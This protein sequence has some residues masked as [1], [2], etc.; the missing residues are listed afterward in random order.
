PINLFISSADELFGPI[1]TIRHMGHPVVHILWSAFA[2]NVS[3][4]EH[5]NDVHGIV[6]DAN[7]LQQSFSS[8]NHGNTL[9]CSSCS[10]RTADKL[11]SEKKYNKV[12]A[13]P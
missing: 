11:G 13:I 2:L 10:Q 4:W 3:D 8:E 9:V 5:I 7:K 6:S 1:T 12:H